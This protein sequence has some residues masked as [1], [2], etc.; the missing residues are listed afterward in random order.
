MTNQ[1]TPLRDRIAAALYDHSHPGWA[2]SFPDLD[3]EQRDTY[4]ARADAVLAVLPATTNQTAEVDRLTAELADYDER[5]Q[6]LT[7]S[8]AAVV[9]EAVRRVHAERD[10]IEDGDDDAVGLRRGL[11][12]AE[13][14]LRRMADET[15]AAETTRTPCS[16]PECDADGTGE[17]CTRHEREDA[18]AEGD[19]E[20]CGPDCPEQPAAGARQDGVQRP[21]LRE[22]HRAAWNALTPEEQTA[23]LAEL[24]AIDEEQDGPQ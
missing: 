23:R 2:I 3:Q 20:L 4:L 12:I 10:D 18:H 24:D 9:H 7:A 21:G 15:P 5:C 22:R 14:V 13:D 8:R 16:V 1:T 17:P 11:A 6:R 19:H